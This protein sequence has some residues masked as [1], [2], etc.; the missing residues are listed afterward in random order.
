MRR[1]AFLLAAGAAAFGGRAAA[2]APVRVLRGDRLVHQ[3]RELR[4]ADILAPDPRGFG[5]GPE[6]YAGAAAAALARLA[7]GGAFTIEEAGAPDRWGRPFVRLWLPREN[8]PVAVQEL[9]LAEGAARVRPESGDD[10]FLDR[11]FAAEAQ[12]RAARAGL[13]ALDAYRV[14]PAGNA[15]GAIGRFALVEGEARS[16]AAARGRVF[17]NFGEDYRTDFTVTAPTR[18]AR[19]WA[20]EGL[21]LSGL[22]G[23]RVRARGHVAKVNG[24]SIELAH[25]RAL[26]LL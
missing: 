21:D 25:R 12:A 5:D 7:A 18:L 23:R 15:T 24:P 19:R 11:L 6:P 20:R 17:L 9:L 16:A 2:E 10:A 26:E 13:W 1:R 22:A 8:G 3:G 4:L 14:F